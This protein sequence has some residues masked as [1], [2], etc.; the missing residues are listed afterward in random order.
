M[1]NFLKAAGLALA[2]I[3][4]PAT[5]PMHAQSN[6][7]LA[8]GVGGQ[9]S[10]DAAN[11]YVDALQFCLQQIGDPTVIDAQTRQMII[12]N[13]STAYATLPADTQAE[14]ANAR[15]VLNQYQASWNY[16]SLQ[17]KQEFGYSVLSLMYG[18]QAA[19]EAVGW[20][21]GGGYGGGSN[22]VGYGDIDTSGGGNVCYGGICETQG[23]TTIIYEDGY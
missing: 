22:S 11:A 20:S 5:I 9:L 6:S 1:K 8:T 21:S 18:E 19:A 3:G 17:Q 4:A 7:I 16:I 13:M 12:N 15:A 14:L 10:M 2:I 23:D